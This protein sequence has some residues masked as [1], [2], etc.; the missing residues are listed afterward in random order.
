[1]FVFP[2]LNE[3][4]KFLFVYIVDQSCAPSKAL[5]GRYTARTMKQNTGRLVECAK[6]CLYKIQFFTIDH[7]REGGGDITKI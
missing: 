4:E 6:R 5:L 7:Q 3:F 2:I 1:M